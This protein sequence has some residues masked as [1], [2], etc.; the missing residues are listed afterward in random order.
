MGITL[1]GIMRG[2]VPRLSQRVSD[3]RDNKEAAVLQVGSRFAELKNKVDAASAKNR[4]Y[5]DNIDTVAKSLAMDKDVVYN[6]FKAYGGNNKTS[7]SHLKNL[8]N[9][10]IAKGKPIP[11]TAVTQTA[12]MLPTKTDETIVSAEGAEVSNFDKAMSLFKNASPDEVFTEFMNRNPQ[13]NETEVR[14]IMSNTMNPAYSPS[15]TIDPKAFI[16]TLD[17]ADKSKKVKYGRFSYLD[18]GVTKLIAATRSNPGEFKKNQLAIAAE[19]PQQLSLAQSLYENGDIDKANQIFEAIESSL[20]GIFPTAVEKGDDKAAL[21]IKNIVDKIMLNNREADRETVVKQ[22]TE[23]VSAQNVSVDGKPAKI[24]YGYENG[25]VTTTTVMQDNFVYGTGESGGGAVVSNLPPKLRDKNKEALKINSQSMANIGSIL[26][27]LSDTPLAYVSVINSVV[28]GI[29]TGTDIMNGLFNSNMNLL[30]GTSF[31][32]EKFKTLNQAGIKLIASAKDQLFN[33]P[34]L[35]DRDLA[36]VL[37]YVAI[38]NRNIGTTQATAA[39]YGLQTALLKDSALRMAQNNNNLALEVPLSD[40][41]IEANIPFKLEEN[42]KLININATISTKLMHSAAKA[43]GFNIM[44]QEQAMKL[45]PAAREAYADNMDLISAQ[46]KDAL[47]DLTI[48]RTLS[49]SEQQAYAGKTTG[50]G[51]DNYNV[52]PNSSNKNILRAFNRKNSFLVPPPKRT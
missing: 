24:I 10:Y 14:K 25:N 17:A 49:S 1:G 50:S 9:A 22:V 11:T 42:G 44:T 26:T 28:G 15:K 27:K 23:L 12:N 33:D 3:V 29:S 36:I 41:E 48:Y 38:I 46:V 43:M 8:A 37:D 18:D 16:G 21:E 5:M 31:D 32:P 4:T 52:I 19:M 39:L 7:M 34:R 51:T 13:L 6:V 35:S 20:V 30:G 47:V 45:P 40:A 2:A